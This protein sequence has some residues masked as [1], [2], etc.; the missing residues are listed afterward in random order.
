MGYPLSTTYRISQKPNLLQKSAVSPRSI[1]AR[2]H[3]LGMV[4]LVAL[5]VLWNIQPATSADRSGFGQDC[6]RFTHD[7]ILGTLWSEK[8]AAEAPY[9]SLMAMAPRLSLRGT[10]LA[11][12]AKQREGQ[13]ITTLEEIFGTSQRGQRE[14]V[15][16]T[17]YQEARSVVLSPNVIATVAHALTLDSVQVRVEPDTDV[18]TVPLH[19][20]HM[21]LA[22]HLSPS[23]EGVPAQVAHINEPYDLALVQ[24]GAE[25][26]ML[27]L[28]YPP[29]LSYGTGNP[30]TPVGG[31]EAG[32]CVATVVIPGNGSTP[33]DGQARLVVG[34][35]LAR[36]PVAVN[37]MTQTKLNVNMFT[38]DLPVKPG[39]SGSPVLALQDGKPV[40]VGL[41]S[42]T[43]YPTAAFTYVSRIDP[44]LALA[45]ALQVAG[46]AR[47]K[48]SRVHYQDGVSLEGQ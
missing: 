37:S 42:A 38:T 11:T 32:D 16:T 18:R 27:P 12:Y 34:K 33:T 8:L 36:V 26:T 21:T 41:V 10:A 9:A 48:Q 23:H 35:V 24:S 28:P 4:L 17:F 5:C 19:V 31:L 1:A 3:T 13:P 30:R 39:D 20:T 14:I 15:E 2:G 43:M 29:A 46:S 45:D 40:L 22:A 47:Q 25:N 44:L 7:P 6:S